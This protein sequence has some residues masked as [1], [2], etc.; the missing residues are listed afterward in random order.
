MEKRDTLRLV[1]EELEERIAPG[2]ITTKGNNGWGN[3]AEGTNPGSD[4][5]LTAPSKLAEAATTDSGPNSGTPNS[6]A[7]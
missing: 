7:R 5:G 4:N 6:L 1:I 3:G 2:V